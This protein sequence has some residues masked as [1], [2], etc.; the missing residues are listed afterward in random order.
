MKQEENA[1]DFYWRGW[2]TLNKKSILF[3]LIIRNEKIYAKNW[4]DTWISQRTKSLKI[5]IFKEIQKWEWDLC[6]VKNCDWND[7]NE[8]F[9]ASEG[10]RATILGC[11]FS[12]HDC[13]T[14]NPTKI[15]VP[16]KSYLLV[17][18]EKIIWIQILRRSG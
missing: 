8:V 14:F 6:W 2:V 9:S 16:N 17:F 3:G 11:N 13:W 7:V 1:N 10:Q 18:I 5:L 4:W 15:I 12:V